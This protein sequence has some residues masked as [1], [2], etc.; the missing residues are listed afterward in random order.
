MK[1]HNIKC[2]A[3]CVTT[4]CFCKLPLNLMDHIQLPCCNSMFH[5][6]CIAKQLNCPYC[7]NKINKSII[8]EVNSILIKK[9]N[10]NKEKE[11]RKSLF[12]KQVK[13]KIEKIIYSRIQ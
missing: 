9:K 3:R 2:D 11:K 1:I 8:N 6:F 12:R 10:E 7:E 5:V 13:E 4:L